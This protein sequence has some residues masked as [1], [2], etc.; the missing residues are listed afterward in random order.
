MSKKRH[1][2]GRVLI[3]PI[4]SSKQFLLSGH[5]TKKIYSWK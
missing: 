1:Y 3:T 4:S 2:V 5:T